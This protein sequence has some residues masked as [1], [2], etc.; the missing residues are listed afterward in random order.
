MQQLAVKREIFRPLYLNFPRLDCLPIPSRVAARAAVHS[1]AANLVAKITEAHGTKSSGRDESNDDSAKNITVGS[2]LVSAKEAG[3]LTEQQFR[4][5]AVIVF[6]AGHENPQLLITSLLYLLAKNKVRNKHSLY[7][8]RVMLTITKKMQ[9]EIREEIANMNS[10]TA[11]KDLLLLNSFI[12]E[13]LRLY[14]PLSQ[15]INRK[16]SCNIVLGPDICIPEGTY[17]GYSALGCGR[18]RETWSLDAE[19]FR[20]ARWG[21]TA[22][23]VARKYKHVK[24]KAKMI[25]F[26]GGSRACLGERL[27]LAEVRSLLAQMLANL[28]WELDPTWTESMTPVSC[29]NPCSNLYILMILIFFFLGRPFVSTHAETQFQRAQAVSKLRKFN[30]RSLILFYCS[31]LF[32]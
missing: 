28:E 30:K 19:E 7:C 3:E 29:K 26:H 13:T 27:A 32:V 2:A 17:V 21:D 9:Q 24:S 6:V 14:P 11:L 1:F 31:N 15:I 8:Q 10:E 4:D 25:A 20:P 18:D 23:E 12:Y 16:T 5:N 22:D